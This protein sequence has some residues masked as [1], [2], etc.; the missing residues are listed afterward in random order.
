VQRQLHARR[1]A[2]GRVRGVEVAEHRVAGV[3]Q[4]VQ[5]HLL[6]LRGIGLHRVSV[7]RNGR[8]RRRE[9]EVDAAVERLAREFDDGA[10]ELAQIDRAALRRVAPRELEQLP[11][12]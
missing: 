2:R 12:Q 4:E 9:D 7:G 3:G 11:H 6:D 8:I 5:H 1:R 10:G